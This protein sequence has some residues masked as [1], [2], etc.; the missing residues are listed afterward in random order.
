MLT[1]SGRGELIWPQSM[2]LQH[3][4]ILFQPL[5]LVLLDGGRKKGIIVKPVYIHNY[6][7]AP[8]VVV[9][10]AFWAT[11]GCHLSGGFWRHVPDFQGFLEC[12]TSAP[13]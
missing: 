1:P 12:S 10:Q 2:R 9:F 3:L 11:L 7:L 13:L 4:G 6:G 5:A 8:G